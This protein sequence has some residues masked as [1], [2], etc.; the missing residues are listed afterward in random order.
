VVRLCRAVGKYA[1]RALLCGL[2]D[3]ELQFACLVAAEEVAACE[4]ISLNP[5]INTQLL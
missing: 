3:Q 5:K 2:A 4:I 1:F